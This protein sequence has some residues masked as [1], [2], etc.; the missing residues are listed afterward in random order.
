QLAA[1]TPPNLDFGTPCET[2]KLLTFMRSSDP[3]T[4][5]D[6]VIPVLDRFVRC[7]TDAT[8]GVA[9]RMAAIALPGREQS[10]FAEGVAAGDATDSSAVFWTRLPDP[11]MGGSLDVSTDSTFA[12]GV[13]TVA[14]STV[15]DGDGTV[16]A[17]VTGLAPHTKYFYR[18]RQG[19][20]TSRVGQLVTAP[21]PADDTTTVRLGWSG[22]S[23]AFNQPF[24]SLDAIRQLNPDAWLYIGDTIYGDDPLA[25][26]VVAQTIPEYE[27]K[28]R[29]NRRDAALRNIMAAMGTYSQWD[30]HEVRNDFAGAVPVFASRMAAGNFAFRRYQPIREDGTDPMRLFRSFQ[31]GSGVEFFLL[32]DRQHRSAKFT[33]CTDSSLS[34]FV[35]TDASSTCPGG[36]DGEALLPS[37]SCASTMADPSR[38]ILGA[39]QKQWL[40]NSLLNSTATFKF[41]MNGPP[42]TELLFDP[43]DRWEAW[44]A[45][46]SDILDFIQS[47]NIKNVIW[48]STDLHAV[49]ISPQQVDATHQTPELVSGSIGEQTLFRELPPSIASLL[50]SLPGLITQVS[51]FDLDRF[52]VVLITVTPGSAAT[53]QFDFLDR[54]GAVIHSVTFNAA[55]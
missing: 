35:S 13:E 49:V 1:A 53:A 37:A 19:T 20:A 31:W 39:A 26:G 30:D 32:D 17:D 3:L 55:P 33:C 15:T 2:Y 27:A 22:D 5:N 47:N 9:D 6:N 24:T 29:A 41:I 46:R 50:P 23:N 10:A 8:A 25:D 43:Y 42:I 18:F 48:L 51:E 44:P 12:T 45:E 21:L 4:P 34:G 16:K 38:T 11:S 36:L 40:K 7:I 28:Y 54:T 14:V 52:N